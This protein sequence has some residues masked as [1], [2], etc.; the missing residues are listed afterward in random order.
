MRQRRAAVLKR[1][2]EGDNACGGGQ[3]VLY[4]LYVQYVQDVSK[5]GQKHDAAACI[6]DDR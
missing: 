6:D 2:P 4:V 3:Y 5:R 1:H